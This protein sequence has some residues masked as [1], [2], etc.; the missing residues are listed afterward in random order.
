M[1][2]IICISGAAAG[3][4]AVAKTLKEEL[5]KRGKCVLLTYLSAPIRRIC[6]EWFDWDGKSDAAGRAMLQY[7]GTD[8][9]RAKRPD[10]WVD[11]TMGL[12]SMMGD[13]W[14]FVI[15]PDCRHANELDLDRYGFQ[16]HHIRV[17]NRACAHDGPLGKTAADFTIMN[18]AARGDIGAV[19]H[20]LVY[21]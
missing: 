6:R 18:D 5:E 17:T 4:D 21:G 16:R 7:V 10:F 3:K 1:S 15:I 8:I 2:E 20:S 11:F 13:E 19:A 12:L 9:V 14:D